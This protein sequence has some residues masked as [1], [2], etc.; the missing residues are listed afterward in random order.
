MVATRDR[1]K[2]I[3]FT[4]GVSIPFE[5][6]FSREEFDKIREG[7]VPEGMEDK[8]FAYFEAPH[9]FLHRSWTGLPVYRVA[10]AANCDGGSV[11]EALCVV[12]EIE[13]TGPEYQAKLLDFLISNLLLGKANPFPVPAGARK[14]AAGL[15]QH[16][17]AG[18]GFPQAH[19]EGHSVRRKWWRLWR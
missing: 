8:W 12:E 6:T 14:S 16:G 3:P 5:G 18:T 2:R 4:S 11:T 7:V 10:L 15:L 13:K 19:P 1:W 17:I 9:L